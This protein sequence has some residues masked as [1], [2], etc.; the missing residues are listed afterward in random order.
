M[1]RFSTTIPG[2]DCMRFPCG[3]GGCGTSAGGN[4]GVCDDTWIY[5]VSDGEVALSLRVASAIYPESVPRDR[6]IEQ[7]KPH[8]IMMHVHAAFPVERE[9]IRARARGQA[10]EYVDDGLCFAVGDGYGLAAKKLYN[11]LVF[12]LGGT[13]AFEQPETFWIGLERAW[14]EFA[15]PAYA[16][17]VDDKFERC[18]HCDGRGIVALHRH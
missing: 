14:K 10:C 12:T 17:R 6:Y 5:A 16:Q 8:G 7:M 2:R 18:N 13:N 1:K 11:D 9:S 3:K 15:E 4:H